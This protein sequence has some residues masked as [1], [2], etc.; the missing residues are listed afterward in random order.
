MADQLQLRRGTTAQMLV[1]TGAQGE[2]VVNT[3]NHSL[4][5]HDGI[6]AGGF[7]TATSGQVT[8]GTFYYNE[9]VGSAA[10]SYILDA[11][12]NTNTPSSYLDGVQFGF[13]TTHPNTGP[14]TAN[15]Q[16]LGV[17]S[18]KF[19]G[20]VD[21]QP[22][23]I[24]GRVYL[25][26]DAGNDWMEIQRKALEAPPQIRTVGASVVSNSM[27]VT[28]QPD[29]Y[30]FR[31]PSL[32]SG[33]VNRRVVTAALSLAIPA[34]ATLGTQ[35]GVQSQIAILAIDNAGTVQLGVCNMAGFTNLDETTLVTTVAITS[36]SNQAN[37]VYSS[38][39]VVGAPFRVVGFVQ[40]TQATAGTWA[41]VP[42][43]IQGQGGQ[44]IIGSTKMILAPLLAATSG[45]AID[46]TG[47][48]AWVKR[49]SMVFSVVSTNGAS[50]VIVQ[51]GS[52]SIQTTNYAGA[53][54]V[55]AAST[56]ATANNSTNFSTGSA[57]ATASF[58]G[59]LTLTH[60]GSN[61]WAAEG[62]VGFSSTA[63]TAVISG[64]VAVSGVLD[65]VRLTTAGGTDAFD[66]GSVT[67]LLEG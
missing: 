5:V 23:D 43:E 17:K 22:G 14:S 6:T 66:A 1:F 11:K 3:D 36:G 33:T 25:I 37:T 40:S 38:S 26:Y 57:G 49:I 61:I 64:S 44:A 45:T 41:T 13:V 9:N 48:P 58:G 7:P 59:R 56:V 12:I 24:S 46:F 19:A 16:S 15:F 51:V 65:R 8:E 60:M 20:G 31:S 50:L 55:L 62:S 39:A 47:I 67:V 42:S 63:T 10:N 18:L 53:T 28:L 35:S 2:V 54:S 21:P 52:G 30:D 4:V 27:T 29:N 34:G 32:G